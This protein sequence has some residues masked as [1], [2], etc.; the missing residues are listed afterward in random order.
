MHQKVLLRGSVILILFV[1]SIAYVNGDEDT[2]AD[3]TI[4]DSLCE[5]DECETDTTVQ[6][7]TTV[8]VT[9]TPESTTI[10]ETTQ[11][12]SKTTK[13][14]H[15]S[16]KYG[17]KRRRPGYGTMSEND[18]SSLNSLNVWIAFGDGWLVDET[19]RSGG[20]GRGDRRNNANYNNEMGD[21]DTDDDYKKENNDKQRAFSRIRFPV[22]HFPNYRQFPITRFPPLMSILPWL[23]IFYD[24]V[25]YQ[26]IIF[27]PTGGI[28]IL[29][30][31]INFYGQRFAVA[32]LIKWGYASLVST[33]APPP[34]N[35][36]VAS[37]VQPSQVVNVANTA[38]TPGLAF[39]EKRVQFTDGVKTNFLHFKP[40]YSQTLVE[41][42]DDT[43]DP[44]F[45][46]NY[47]SD[48]NYDTTS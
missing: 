13:K 37:L 3:T 38:P 12:P 1:L 24:K 27:S 23:P 42:E 19:P 10:V 29:P 6:E 33:G 44:P 34:P 21:E 8:T 7:D 43:Y 14:R 26:T 15:K 9:V 35:V 4:V 11:K 46:K 20:R 40:Q 25:T 41:G 18:R 28:Y 31:L 30:P 47:G 39:D 36:D 48:S 22:R 45:N 17:N 5:G 2:T 16:S 32:Q